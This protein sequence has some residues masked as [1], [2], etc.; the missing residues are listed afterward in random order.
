MKYLLLVLTLLIPNIAFTKNSIKIHALHKESFSCIEHWDGQFKHV[1]DALGTDCVI[2]VLVGEKNRYF[3]KSYVADGFNNK[4]WFG[5]K[6]GVLA[7]CDCTIEKI[8]SN[9]VTNKPGIMQPG[10]ASSILF[11]MRDKTKIVLAHLDDIVVK[12]GQK[13]KA[14]ELVAR[15][16]NNG[17]SRNPHVHVAA[18]KGNT[19]LQI[20]FDQKTLELQERSLIAK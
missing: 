2:Q 15:V 8:H 14:G 13:V 20:R 19:P 7:P 11:S 1:G 9:P 18:W 10:K 6:K 5:Y 4:D 12:E 3:M 16:G 17:Y